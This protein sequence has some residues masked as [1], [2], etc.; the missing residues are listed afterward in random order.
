M[1]LESRAGLTPGTNNLH[2]V[3]RSDEIDLAPWLD[4]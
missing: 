2:F 3:A 4:D 1:K